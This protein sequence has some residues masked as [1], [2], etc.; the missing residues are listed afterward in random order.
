MIDGDE[1][2]RNRDPT[3]NVDQSDLLSYGIGHLNQGWFYTCVQP[4]RDGVTL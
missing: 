2:Y 3:N 4:M 1:S